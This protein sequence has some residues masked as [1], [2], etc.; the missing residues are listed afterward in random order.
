M[1]TRVLLR[2]VQ[3]LD[4]PQRPPRCC[5]VLV[6]DGVIRCLGDGAAGQDCLEMAAGHLWLAPALVDPHSV[7]EDPL[8]GTA[9]TLAS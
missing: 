5:D 8:H 1:A 2:Q 7:L 3:L 6:E 4:H 9:E